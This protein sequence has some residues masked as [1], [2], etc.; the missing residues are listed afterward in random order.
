MKKFTDEDV[1]EDPSLLP[2]VREYLAG[3]EGTFSPLVQAKEHFFLFGLYPTVSRD[4]LTA[5]TVL[6][7]MIHDYEWSDKLPETRGRRR[8]N[9]WNRKITTRKMQ[10]SVDA[11]HGGHR[12]LDSQGE[13]HSCEGVPYPINRK[14]TWTAARINRPLA[15]SRGGKLVH[16]TT[17]QGEI[18]WIPL[19]PHEYGESLPI[20]IKVKLVCKYPSWLKNPRLLSVDEA[21]AYISASAG[22]I[23]VCPHCEKALVDPR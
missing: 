5:R 4:V 23:L 16:H 1:R 17:G 12:W 9:Q 14:M 2:L 22:E 18:K 15:A 10:C 21:L 20:E 6:N 7:C 3:Y 8:H 19:D 11:P 13:D